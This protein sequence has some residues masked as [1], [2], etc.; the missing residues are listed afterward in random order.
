[1]RTTYITAIVIALLLLGWLYSGD[2]SD[3]EPQAT[4]AEQ[5]RESAR[6]SSDNIPT[7]VRVATLD[8]SE[9]PRLVKVR[10][11]T[12]NK[13]TV[14]VRA[15]LAGTITNRPVERGS[16]VS[17]GD[18]LCQISTEDREAS[19]LEAKAQVLQARI[20]YEGAV[21]LKRQGFNSDSAIAAAKA[22]LASADA[23][24][25]RS[26]LDLTKLAVN[27]PFAGVIEDVHSEVGDYITP[28]QACATVVDLDPMLITGRVS[29]KD[30]A[31]LEKGQE[32]TGRFRDGTFVTGTMTFIGHQ[33]DASTRTYPIEIQLPNP[34]YTIRSGITT[35]IEIP[36]ESVL[37][38][39]VTPAVFSLDDEGAIGIRTINQN[40]I[41]EFH[42][43]DVLSDSPEGVWVTGLPARANVIIVGQELVVPGERVDPVFE[44]QMTLPAST[45]PEQSAPIALDPNSSTAVT[46]ATTVVASG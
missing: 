46:A 9:Q 19:L 26:E 13:R 42:V 31:T 22:R 34:D 7:Q 40:N 29:E 16:R 1:M 33:S 23:Q 41:V 32:A 20:D 12:Q 24:L 8:A 18:L 27:A 28:G 3:P 25:K 21:K 10:G 39:R 38:Q 35:E 4:I 15:E 5:N 44:S 37:A 14:S 11:K 30:V 36:V 43:I 17:E 2:H 6:V 45:Q